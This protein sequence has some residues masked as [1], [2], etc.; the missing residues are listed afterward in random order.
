MHFYFIAQSS[1]SITL[2]GDAEALWATYTWTVE[3]IVIQ[4]KRRVLMEKTLNVQDQRTHEKTKTYH[5]VPVLVLIVLGLHTVWSITL[6]ILL[7]EY[8]FPR[9]QSRP[10]LGRMGLSIDAAIYVLICLFLWRAITSR[11]HFSA[12]PSALIGTA[13][14]VAALVSLALLVVPRLTAAPGARKAPAPWL[15]GLTAFLAAT[16]FSAM[17]LLLPHMPAVPLLVSMLLYVAVYVIMI[18]LV[19]RWS[20][21]RQWGARHHLALATGALIETMLFGFLLVSRGSPADL[22]F[23]AV[24]CVVILLLLPW[25]ARGLRASEASREVKGIS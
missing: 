10:W 19:W 16:L 14:L 1:A 20:T 3:K 24:L 18:I 5:F 7:A 6:P 12:S 25:I 11:T 21:Q 2:A 9:L 8:L 4:P 15:V 22:I 23:H 17:F 13:L